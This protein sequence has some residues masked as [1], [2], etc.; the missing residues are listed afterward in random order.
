MLMVRATGFLVA[1]AAALIGLVLHCLSAG[2]AEPAPQALDL[3]GYSASV[4]NAAMASRGAGGDRSTGSWVNSTNGP[5]VF[6][7]GV[8]YQAPQ[9]APVGSVVRPASPVRR[10]NWRYSFLT[11]APH[12]LRAYLCNYVRC[13]A[14]SGASGTTAAFNGDSAYSNFSFAFVI[15]GSGGM[16]PALQGQ[17]NYVAVSYE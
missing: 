1:G 4:S 14:L 2:A 3:H 11:P 13:I 15:D 5:A 17:S 12:G 9:I 6:H 10:V 16:S 8:I 7:R